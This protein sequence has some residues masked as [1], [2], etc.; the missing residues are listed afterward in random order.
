MLNVKYN[1][2]KQ[3]SCS[4]IT[5][6]IFKILFFLNKVITKY[7]TIFFIELSAQKAEFSLITCNR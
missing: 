1:I 6:K 4:Q 2:F 7:G 5:L 3:K